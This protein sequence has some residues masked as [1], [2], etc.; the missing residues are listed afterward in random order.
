MKF[1]NKLYSFMYGRYGID[2]LY[3][4]LLRISFIL[5]IINLFVKSKI[6]SLIALLLMYYII[7]RALSKNINTRRK[8]NRLFLKYKNKITNIFKISYNKDKEHIYKKCRY[9]KT[10]LKLPLPEKIGIKK[11]KCPGC[12]KRIKFLVLRKEKR[13]KVI[14]PKR[15]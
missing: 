12:G 5:I 7:F 1:I 9:C 15:G 2:E 6:I 11:S 8:E 14:K 10:I 4:F 13:V 3:K